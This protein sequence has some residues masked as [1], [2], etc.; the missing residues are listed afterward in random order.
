MS[1]SK[2]A[3]PKKSK[4]PSKKGGVQIFLV[5]FIIL[6]A[7][8]L[9]TAFVLIVGLLPMVVAFFADRAPKKTKSITVGA[10]N[11]AGCAP[12]LLLLWTTDHSLDKAMSI[13]FDPMAIVVI[14][15]AA[16]VG[17]F[18]DWALS[19]LVANFM[20]EKGQSHVK[21]IEKR[22]KE[23]IERWGQEVTGTIPVDQEGFPVESI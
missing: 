17:Y 5:A 13:I 18:I 4:A 14:Y 22:Q 6:A 20:Y 7:V 10:M 19:I 15:A 12:F 21:A 1:K 16:A 9:P 8:F 11:L 3:P 2:K 23:L